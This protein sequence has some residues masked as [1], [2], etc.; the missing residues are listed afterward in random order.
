MSAP[1][2]VRE[3]RFGLVLDAFPARLAAASSV[4]LLGN[5]DTRMFSLSRRLWQDDHGF[6]V[7]SELVLIATVGVLGLLAGLT[8]VRD[9]VTAELKDVAGSIGSL[10]QSYCYSGFRSFKGWSG[11]VKAWTAGSSFSDSEDGDRQVAAFDCVPR[12]YEAAPNPQP[13]CID[14]PLPPTLPV[15]PACPPELGPPPCQDALP[16]PQFAPSISPC[17]CP[18]APGECCPSAATPCE[19]TAPCQSTATPACPNPGHPCF[20]P[21]PLVW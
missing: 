12:V 15:P 18:A 1:P 3:A 5:G 8:C 6:L 4:V 19:G 17:P 21:Q 11:G 10:N 7:S 20:P 9:A 2:R 14:Q 13:P 16:C